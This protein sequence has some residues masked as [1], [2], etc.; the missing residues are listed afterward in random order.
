MS[1]AIENV[2]IEIK[3]AV[4]PQIYGWTDCGVS[5]EKDCL[6]CSFPAVV[7]VNAMRC[8]MKRPVDRD[9]GWDRGDRGKLV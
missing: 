8:S 6:G 4:R 1:K 7:T 5:E 3:R 2:K 9:L